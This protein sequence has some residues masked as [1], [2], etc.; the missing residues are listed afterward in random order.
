[1]AETGLLSS[2]S[3]MI[4][5]PGPEEFEKSRLFS[6]SLAVVDPLVAKYISY[7]NLL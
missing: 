7:S 1:M 4:I 2:C 5:V 6:A 3:E